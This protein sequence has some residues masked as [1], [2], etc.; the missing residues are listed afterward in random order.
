MDSP[1]ELFD[2]IQ[3]FPKVSI[4]E[5]ILQ[6]AEARLDFMPQEEI[7]NLAYNYIADEF[8]TH[9]DDELRLLYADLLEADL[10]EADLLEAEERDDER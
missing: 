1:Y 2:R 3:S 10:L 8:R 6:L 4:N 7:M 5:M 9:S